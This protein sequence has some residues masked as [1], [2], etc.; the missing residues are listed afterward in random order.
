[1]VF[2]A[3]QKYKGS[4]KWDTVHNL[5]DAGSVFKKDGVDIFTDGWSKKAAVYEPICHGELSPNDNSFHAIAKNIWQ[6]KRQKFRTEAQQALY[7]LHLCDKVESK[8]VSAQFTRN[9][10]LDKKKLSYKDVEAILRP[11]KALKKDEIKQ[12]NSCRARYQKWKVE[13]KKS[14]SPTNF[15][16]N[17]ILDG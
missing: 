10:Q 14:D 7:L 16:I 4:V 2:T 13:I 3:L 9:L 12:L 5:R 17:A 6:S 15:D 11:N 8:T 1:M